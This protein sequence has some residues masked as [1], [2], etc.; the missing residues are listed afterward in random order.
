MSQEKNVERSLSMPLRVVV[1]LETK[2][3]E[4]GI[5]PNVLAAQ[6]LE[7]G[8]KRVRTTVAARADP[9]SPRRGLSSV[10]GVSPHE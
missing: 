1:L 7:R 5:R 2:A 3:R 6:V 10:S 4:S 8:L 9:D